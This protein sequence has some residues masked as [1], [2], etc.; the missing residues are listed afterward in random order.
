MRSLRSTIGLGL[1]GLFLAGCAGI[2]VAPVVPPGGLLYSELSAPIDIGVNKTQLGS[3]VGRSMSTS[4][5]G[6]V[7]TGDCCIAAAAK[8]GNFRTI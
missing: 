8:G 3:K 6:L 4:L 7:A 2:Y 5:L 1:L